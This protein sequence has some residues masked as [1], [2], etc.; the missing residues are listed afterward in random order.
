MNTG[1]KHL[2]GIRGLSAEE[3]T[4]FLDTAESF[5]EIS[6]REIKK[7]PALRG[8][9]VINLFFEPSTR[10]RTSFEIAGKRLSADVINISS[11]SS[12]V[13]KG[14]TLL[15]TA[16]NLEAMAPDL[17]V[18]RHPS[19]GAPHQLARVCR[20]A[21]V[22]AGDGAHEHPTQ[23]LLDALTIRQHKGTFR[24]L[25][26]AILGDLLHSRVARSNAHLLTTLGASV[27]LAGPGTLAPPEFASVVAGGGLRVVNRV[28]EAIEGADV[29]MVLR[30]QRERQDKAFLPSL[31]EYA[32]HFGLNRKRLELAAPDAIVMHPGPMNRGI[33]IA[34]D[35]ADGTRSLILDQVSNGLALRMAVLYLLGG[36]AGTTNANIN[37]PSQIKAEPEPE[38]LR[39]A[40]TAG[41]SD[42]SN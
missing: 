40:V 29:V 24:G 33:E 19:A 41:H 38:P 15:D 30:I 14:E 1:L 26:V 4:H 10:T 3:I 16:R 6:G 7:V 8:R 28:E 25:R 12:S 11:S 27:T 13:T 31:R 32:V 22:N 5:R 42:Q 35:V 39:A 37:P 20:A 34:S 21:I 36:A 18:V 2:L 17:I 23:A 9:T